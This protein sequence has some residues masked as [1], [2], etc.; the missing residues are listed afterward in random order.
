MEKI[1]DKNVFRRDNLTKIRKYT[2]IYENIN[3]NFAKG[4]GKMETKRF[5]RGAGILLPIT[6]LP[7]PYGIGTLGQEAYQFVD[8]LTDLRQRYWQVL[9]I[10]PTSYGDSPYQAFSAFA[11]NP[12]LIDLEM[13][14]KDGLIELSDIR[15]FFWGSNEREIDYAV[16]HKNRFSILRLAYERFDK[17]NIS[18]RIF[19]EKE[20]EWLA[21]YSLF[22]SVKM[23]FQEKEWSLWD[24]DIRNRTSAGLEK[25]SSL[26]CQE[27]DFWNFCQYKFYEQWTILKNYA[28]RKG[29]EIIGDIPLY[30]ALD[31]SDVWANKR[32]FL[33]DQDG[34]PMEVAGCPPDAF[35]QDG[36]KWGNPLYD[37]KW[38]ESD[39]FSWWKKRMEANTKL[40][41]IIRIDHFIGIVRYYSI[42][43]RDK[44][45]RLGRWN[46]GPGKKLTDAIMEVIGNKK[47][48][49]EDLGV[50]VPGVQKL[51]A[52]TGWPNMKILQFAFDGNT[53]HEF[54]PHNYRDENIV[55][56]G[57]T[58][59]NET[60][61]GYFR[62]K[63]DYEL[64]FMYA[65]LNIQNKDEIPDALIRLAYSSI[66]NV[67]I[68][69]IQDILKLGNEART[70]FPSTVG[71]NWKF[72]IWKNCMDENR[73]TWIRTIAAIYRR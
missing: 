64:A 56:Y 38:M 22:M 15:S 43:A 29:I 2:K 48:I 45:A 18:F 5:A 44:T 8:L 67:V 3:C 71:Q 61:V 68:F 41:D 27:I 12:Y 6:S 25:Y 28:N 63:T 39:G 53:A 1:V 24:L 47:I 66:A 11:G 54:L 55:V 40:Y 14:Y 70:N 7:S 62:E 26:L 21:D 30:V 19:C 46:R 69:Q 10:G 57:G 49:V 50:A 4:D 42:P 13:L 52:K 60:L 58:H 37:W 73:R 65:Y 36:Q 23:H 34:N 59:D 20:Q 33:L 35:S 16:L 31:S 72:R 32:L 17:S 51:I 9:P